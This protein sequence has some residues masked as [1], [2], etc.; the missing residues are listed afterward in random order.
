[1]QKDGW[2]A[3]EHDIVNEYRWWSLDE[4]RHTDDIVFPGELPMLL[5][6]LLAGGVPAEPLVLAWL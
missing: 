6:R 3:L 5:E 2:S 1:M 4:L